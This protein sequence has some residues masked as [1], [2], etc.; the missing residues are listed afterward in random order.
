MSRVKAVDQCLEQLNHIVLGKKTETQLAL[1]CILA[2]GHLLIEDIPGMG[3]TTLSHALANILGL[4]YKRVQ[5]TSD[6]LPSDILGGNIFDRNSG[7]FLFQKG[8]VFTNVLLADEINRAPP[9]TQSALLEAMEERQ[10]SYDGKTRALAEPFF[11]IATQNP[12]EQ[13]GTYSLP[14]SQLDRFMMR[15]SLGYPAMEAEK[16][17]LKGVSRQQLMKELKASLSAETLIKLQALVAKTTVSDAVVDYVYRLV[18]TSRSLDQQ[19]GLSPRAALALIAAAKAW[20]FIEGRS[21]ILPD[22]IQAV[23]PYVCDHR[24]PKL[25]GE[26]EPSSKKV[27]KAVDIF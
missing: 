3:K 4:D 7:K 13:S 1:T 10:I 11:V 25:S 19:H 22:D 12:L 5:F 9:K 16:A 15:I 27:L 23:F 14:E 21:H 17:L 24:M 8:P 2:R 20:A 26:T 18:N 6:M